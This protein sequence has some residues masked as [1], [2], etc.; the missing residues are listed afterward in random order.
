MPAAALHYVGSRTKENSMATDKTILDV[1]GYT[2]PYVGPD[3]RLVL[4]IDTDQQG[5][6]MLV[7]DNAL[8]TDLA[9]AFITSVANRFEAARFVG[10]VAK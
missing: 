5:P 1:N 2:N 7:V 10:K 4:S 3:G 8:V 6:V 9:L